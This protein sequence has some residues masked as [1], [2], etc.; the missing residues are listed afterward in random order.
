MGKINALLNKKDLEKGLKA[1]WFPIYNQLQ[2]KISSDNCEKEIIGYTRKFYDATS[3]VNIRCISEIS[4]KS[5][6]IV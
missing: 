5:C 3:M 2:N 1:C 4:F 6:S